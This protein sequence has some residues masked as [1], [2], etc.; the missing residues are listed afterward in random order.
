M[1]D[2]IISHSKL[3][4]PLH[5]DGL[6]S[7][8]GWPSLILPLF[9]PYAHGCVRPLIICCFYNWSFSM[10]ELLCEERKQG[11]WL[12]ELSEG[13]EPSDWFTWLN[14]KRH[15][16]THAY[17]ELF[18]Y[19]VSVPGCVWGGSGS[20]TKSWSASWRSSLRL[21]WFLC[22]YRSDLI[23]FSTYILFILLLSN[24]H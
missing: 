10:S 17:T 23:H 22:Q 1:P 5:S 12:N 4:A 14:A 3:S 2:E 19:P 15:T 7:Q 8:L 20:R 9:R 21:W 6:P 24:L 18:V 16:L 11:H 13:F